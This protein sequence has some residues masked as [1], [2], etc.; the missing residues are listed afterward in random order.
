[1]RGVPGTWQTTVTGLLLLAAMVAG[2]LVQRGA[3]E[4]ATGE[5]IVDEFAGMTP[6]PRPDDRAAPSAV[7]T[8]VLVA[9]FVVDQSPLRHLAESRGAGRAERRARRSSRSAR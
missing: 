4:A 3:G 2:R 6:G 7:A 5:A 8:L 9:V 1:M